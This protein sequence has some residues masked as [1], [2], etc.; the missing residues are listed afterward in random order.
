MCR[1]PV[2]IEEGIPLE[3]PAKKLN[4]INCDLVNTQFLFIQ[5]DTNTCIEMCH[6]KQD[7]ANFHPSLQMPALR[8]QS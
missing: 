6:S 2:C 1:M 5:E 3:M 7:C 8:V 4:E